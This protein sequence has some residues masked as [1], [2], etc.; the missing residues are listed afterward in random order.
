MGIVNLV[1]GGL[2][3]SLIS[4]MLVEENQLIYPLFIDYGQLAAEAE[5]DACSKIHAKL[6]IDTPVRMDLNGYGAIIN[7][8]LTSSEKHIRDDAFTPGRNMMFLLMASSYAFQV[9]ANGVAI[10]LLSEQ[11]SLFSDQTNKFLSEAQ[12]AINTALGRTIEIVAPLMTFSKADV[13]KLAIEKGLSGTYSCHA[14]QSDPCGICISCLEISRN[15][16][17]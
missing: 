12:R 8:G 15:K 13:V 2:D 6:G 16:S 7:S 14:G 9:G 3:S 10:G 1:S 5:W 17:R 11:F 4:H